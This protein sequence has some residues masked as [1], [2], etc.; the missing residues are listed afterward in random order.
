MTTARA[1][2]PASPG[3]VLA[4][5]GAELVR[6]LSVRFTER[7]WRC[8]VRA[9]ESPSGGEEITVDDNGA[10]SPDHAHPTFPVDARPIEEQVEQVLAD[11]EQ[12]GWAGPPL[13]R[14]ALWCEPA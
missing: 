10:V 9:R 14:A 3:P 2:P 8:R 5:Q 7:G 12:R 11:L 6:E 1:T 13:E 4:G